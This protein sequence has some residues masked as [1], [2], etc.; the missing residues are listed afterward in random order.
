MS[1][2]ESTL[3]AGSFLVVAACA[4]LGPQPAPAAQPSQAAAWESSTLYARDGTA[5]SVNADPQTPATEAA[6]REL[7]PSESGRMY[8][9]ELYQKAIDERDALQRELATLGGDADHAKTQLEQALKQL[10][11]LQARVA[12]LESENQRRVDENIDLAGRLVTAQIRRLQ[13]EKILLEQRLE[14]KPQ[15]TP[16][17]VAKKP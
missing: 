1:K 9:L 3:T 4:S 16:A 8:I 14:Q 13:V 7:R 10:A 12:Q 5:V 11:E 15:A 17:E 6:P 2:L